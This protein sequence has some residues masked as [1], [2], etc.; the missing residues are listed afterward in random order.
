MEALE[1]YV[2]YTYNINE[3]L[4]EIKKEPRQEAKDLSP[5]KEDLGINILNI[6]E[7]RILSPECIKFYNGEQL[8][9]L[10]HTFLKN[11]L[12]LSNESATE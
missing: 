4:A 10:L 12:I 1:A 9:A 11:N 3:H 8:V 6:I 5:G 7:K 2:Y